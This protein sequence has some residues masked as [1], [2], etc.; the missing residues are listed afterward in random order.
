MT[1]F[2]D[3]LWNDIVRDHGP[4]LAHIERREPARA[5]LLRRPRFIA[6]STLGLAGAGTALVL[7]LG[8]ASSPPAFAVTTNSNG[9]VTMQISLTSSLPQANAKLLAMG[10]HE[11]V[12]IY[13][14]TGP[15][16]A[17]GAVACTPAAGA[18]VSGPPIAVLVGTDGTEVINAGQTADNT[19]EGTWHLAR[20]TFA[21]EAST[22]PH[23]GSGTG[24]T[25][26]TGNTGAG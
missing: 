17:S 15:A 11:Q 8:V 25:G 5:R 1:K 26:N 21:P 16:A 18:S 24:N 13:M 20:C 10:I 6:G 14:A 2:T 12:A 9:S 4:A 3:N 23:S 19:G 7:A 22:G